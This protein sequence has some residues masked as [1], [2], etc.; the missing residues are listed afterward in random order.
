MRP[1]LGT[2]VLVV[3]FALSATAVL[4]HGDEDKALDK[5]PARALAQQALAMLS[6]EGKVGEAQE[7]IEAA[8]ESMDREGVDMALLRRTRQA[9]EANDQAAAARLIGAALLADGGGREKGSADSNK[10]DP[11]TLEHQPEFEPGRGTAEWVA[12]GLGVAAI[13]A[14]SALLLRS[15]QRTA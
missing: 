3:A 10:V 2:V 14:A 5:M 6:Q 7:R 12:V 15:R 11:A 1:A 13:V 8:L 4:A 9:L